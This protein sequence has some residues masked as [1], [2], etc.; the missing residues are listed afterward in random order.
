[1]K[2]KVLVNALTNWLDQSIRESVDSLVGMA[3]IHP[4]SLNKNNERGCSTPF[5]TN[6]LDQSIRES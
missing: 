1:M 4:L 5:Q 2:R 6:W 3:P